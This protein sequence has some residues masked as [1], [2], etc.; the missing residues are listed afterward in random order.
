MMP[1]WI[2]IGSSVAAILWVPLTY[3]RIEAGTIL[4][5]MFAGTNALLLLPIAAPGIRRRRGAR[6]RIK[7][8]YS[9]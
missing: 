5:M 7:V 1:H 9:T 3:Y 2:A 4:M 8:E 6:R